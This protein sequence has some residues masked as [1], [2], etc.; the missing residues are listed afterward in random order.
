MS[1]DV[2]FERLLEFV[3]DVRG[4]DY[5]GYR[6]PTLIRRFEKRMQAV[7]AGDWSEYRRHLEDHPGEFDELFNA[8]LINVTGFFRDPETWELVASDVIP[9]VLEEKPSESPIR[10]WS[11]GCASGE[12]A[13]TIA[14]LLADALGD[15][16]YRERVKIYATDIDDEALTEARDS[17]YTSK[18]L[19]EVPAEL[20]ERFFQ[21][22]NHSF[23]FRPELRRS[24]IFGRNDLHKDP[25]I[26]RVDL[27]V[28]RNTLM[29]FS[30]ELQE[31]ILANFHFALN[32]GG[33]LIVGKAEA[34]QRGRQFFAPYDLKRRIFVKDGRAH[35]AFYVPRPP[36]ALAPMLEG[37][38]AGELEDAAFEHSSVAQLVID[39]ESRVAAV[40]QSARALFAI[41]LK[42]IGRP[43]QDLE[44]S[45]RP[46][47]LRSLVDEVRRQRRPAGVKNVTWESARG[48]VRSLDVQLAP[49]VGRGDRLIGVSVSFVDATAHRSLE[50]Q[51]ETSRRE[52]ETA[53]EELQ[54]TVE[55]LETT[56]EELQS[57]NEELE[58]TN[59]ELQSTNEELETMN[60]ELQSTNEELETMN[61]ELRERTDETQRSNA[62]MTSVLASIR[63]TVIVV[64]TELSVIAWSTHATELLGLRDDEVEGHHLLN[65]D[66]GLPVERLADPIRH[67]L[68]GAPEETVTL[69][70]HDRRGHPTRYEIRVAPLIG[71]YADAPIGGAILL[72]GAERAG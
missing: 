34:L 61:D 47:E 21:P 17:T 58:T 1:V 31:R 23:G 52:L 71:H 67:V 72:L 22:V 49:L 55:E 11:A 64:D 68:A 9:K 28:S 3:R 51:L 27:L 36:N 10:V 60:E 54:S 14:M 62:F 37:R 15:E 44:V 39:D 48:S 70:G 40:N 59:E 41:K 57:T 30:A 43:L 2:E 4:F 33:F 53:Y 45:Y 46:V 16:A 66:I 56:N 63:Q 7:G 32:R 38:D 29:Y 65:L 6:R 13:Y 5:A 26:S 24:V 19:S 35:P 69:E 25:P 8:I 42:D 18:Q 50:Q 12:E 20:R